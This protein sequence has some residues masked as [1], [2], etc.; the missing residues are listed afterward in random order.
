MPA[1]IPNTFSVRELFPQPQFS[2]DVSVDVDVDVDADFNV[3]VDLEFNP[4]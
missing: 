4:S 3:D 1:R 2:K